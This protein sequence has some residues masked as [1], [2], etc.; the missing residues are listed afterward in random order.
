[1]KLK[2]YAACQNDVLISPSILS[3]DFAALGADIAR[4]SETADTIH[5]DVMDGR[6][7]P[8]LTIGMPVVKA[9]RPYT[10][11]P[12]DCHLMIEDPAR[13]VEAFA[14]AGADLITVHAETCPHLHRVTQQ[15]RACGCGVGVV[16][17]PATSLSALE[18]ILP[19][20]DLVLLMSVNPGFGGQAYIESVTDK[21]RRLR[22]QMQERD[23]QA[24]IQVDGGVGP[25]NIQKLWEAGANCFVAGSSVYG[26]PDP[27]QA[28]SELKSCARSS[29]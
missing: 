4:V 11:L 3:A 29:F 6:F 20:V 23:I 8:N 9:I 14:E 1:M 26:K 22:R 10:D 27:V 15:I 18:E 17:N 19:E 21:I 7:V 12:I 25:S 16:I 2:P 5:V 13:Y 28:I 24:H